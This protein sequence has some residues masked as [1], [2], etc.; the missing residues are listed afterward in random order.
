MKKIQIQYHSVTKGDY[1]VEAEVSEEVME[2]IKKSE[3]EMEN[4]ERRRSYHGTLSIDGI[5]Y[6]GKDY[7]S[8]L[9]VSKEVEKREMFRRF[10]EA[11]RQLPE[12]QQ[13]RLELKMQGYSYQEIA[14]REKAS[15]S[16]VYES[17]Q[18]AKKRL[19]KVLDDS[20]D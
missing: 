5:M 15:L 11:F 1:E 12:T 7:A 18:A 6:E 10:G 4:F 19:K 8:N 17:V 9:D 2:V 16:A 13:R 3:R 14:E 20:A